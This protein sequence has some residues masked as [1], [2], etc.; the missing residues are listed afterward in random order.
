MENILGLLIFI[1]FIVARAMMDR[2]RG[3]SKKPGRK[4]PPA[5]VPRR[6]E[7]RES[8]AAK[9][10]L[11][12]TNPRPDDEKPIPL[13][14]EGESDDDSLPY[15]VEDKKPWPPKR[16]QTV[17]V[18]TAVAI[19][20]QEYALTIED[21]RKAVIWSEILQRPRFRTRLRYLR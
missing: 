14:V 17:S 7:A 13:L 15:V 9:P 20:E 3:M 18:Q 21:L 10:R 2:N 11:T 6:T 16:E 1:L 5:A 19:S 4:R 8:P 12:P